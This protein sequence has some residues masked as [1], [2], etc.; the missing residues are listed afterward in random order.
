[1]GDRPCPG[2]HSHHTHCHRYP[3]VQEV[4]AGLAPGD[5]LL[6]ASQVLWCSIK[7]A[8][9]AWP[10]GKP[11]ATET[12]VLCVCTSEPPTFMRKGRGELCM[13]LG[14]SVHLFLCM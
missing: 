3:P 11:G 5:S 2:G 9:S 6:L 13:S 1:M 4:S 14:M 8:I 12:V 10:L 7:S